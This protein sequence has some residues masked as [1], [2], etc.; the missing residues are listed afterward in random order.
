MKDTRSNF[1]LFKTENEKSIVQNLH[2]AHPDKPLKYFD[3]NVIISVGY[4]VKSQRGTQFGMWATKHQ[5]H[6][7]TQQATSLS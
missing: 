7:S 3:L 2:I 1:I 5:Q 6:E 4:R